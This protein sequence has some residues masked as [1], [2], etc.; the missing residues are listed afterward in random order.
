M[1]HLHHLSRLR[2]SWPISPDIGNLSH[3]LFTILGGIWETSESLYK[4]NVKLGES[5]VLSFPAL[6]SYIMYSCEYSDGKGY[7]S[8][9]PMPY[10]I[11]F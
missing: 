10:K 2:S 3:L 6:F 5:D 4:Q 11:N 7:I 9:N 1:I 8:D